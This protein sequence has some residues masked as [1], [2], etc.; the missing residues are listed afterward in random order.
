MALRLQ[1]I[2]VGAVAYLDHKTLLGEPDLHK[3]SDTIDRPGPFVCVQVK[4]KLSAWAPLTGEHR[5]ERL[6]IDSKW[7]RDG[8]DY[9]QTHDQYLSDGLNTWVGP[10]EAFV[11]AGAKETPFK[12]YRRPSVTSAGI[13]AIL[14]E[15][16][17]QGGKLL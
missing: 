3:G 5:P 11:R 17:R 15:I 2:R 6:L 8:S 13:K 4:G 1:D 7:R 12:M 14:A 10:S 9:W 16:E